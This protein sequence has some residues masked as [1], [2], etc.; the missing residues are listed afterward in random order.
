MDKTMMDNTI[1][2]HLMSTIMTKNEM[3]TPTVMDTPVMDTT[4]D[5]WLGPYDILISNAIDH[6]PAKDGFNT[7]YKDGTETKNSM[8][9]GMWEGPP[10]EAQYKENRAVLGDDG[11]YYWKQ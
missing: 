2:Q 11:K 1:Y 10:S 6:V 5:Y 8:W 3:D 9:C 7:V 4:T